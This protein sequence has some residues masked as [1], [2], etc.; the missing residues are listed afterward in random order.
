MGGGASHRD[1][2]PHHVKVILQ[3][4]HF[5][6]MGWPLHP[7]RCLLSNGHGRRMARCLKSCFGAN[8]IF[9]VWGTALSGLAVSSV[10]G[11]L[12]G[13]HGFYKEDGNQPLNGLPG[14]LPEQILRT[15]PEGA[16]ERVT[17]LRLRSVFSRCL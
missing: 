17:A 3:G 10:S 8:P 9:V 12:I 11:R 4:P 13:A 5:A 16:R 1:D 7:R 2:A 6:N 14:S 15:C